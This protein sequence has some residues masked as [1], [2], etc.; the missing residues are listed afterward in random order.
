MSVR[1]R[2]FAGAGEAYGESEAWIE[3]A[4]DVASLVAALVAAG[5]PGTAE[6]LS[7]CALI[8]DGVRADAPDTPVR[9]GALVDVLPPFA[10]G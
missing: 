10:G 5:G 7:R 9:D 2:L 6:V 1:V 8:V 3:H 4:G